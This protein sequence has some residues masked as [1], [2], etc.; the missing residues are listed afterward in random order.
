MAGGTITEKAIN[1]SFQNGID[2]NLVINPSYAYIAPFS[3]GTGWNE[4]QLGAFISFVKTG[5]GNENDS[6]PDAGTLNF[7][8]QLGGNSNDEF[9]YFGIAKT[10]ANQ[11]GNLP[12]G[13]DQ[14]GFIGLRGDAI[15]I[16]D[17]NAVNINRINN[18]KE[19]DSNIS[20]NALFFSSSGT[21]MLETGSFNPNRG[22]YLCVGLDSGN[23][24]E[25]ADNLGS[26]AQPFACAEHTDRFCAYWGARF[27]IINKGQSNQLIR[28]TAQHRHFGAGGVAGAKDPADALTDIADIR[29][30]GATTDVSTG[31]LSALLDGN[32]VV[33]FS[34]G[35]ASDGVGH[36]VN[37]HGPTTGFIFNN[38]GS[39]VPVP[40]A[41]YIYNGFNTVRP[42]VHAWGVKIVS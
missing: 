5:D 31:A 37:G 19:L 35:D 25:G 30:D 34:D 6:F 33:H 24:T 42:R 14:S 21:T 17:S 15:Q 8:E 13:S 20:G 1:S 11:T 39:H 40:D 4:I 41:F 29:N 3:F 27:K 10:G 26:D 16:D 12:S 38:G 7:T 23:A 32:N 22:N 36:A 2:K 9:F 28:F 18:V